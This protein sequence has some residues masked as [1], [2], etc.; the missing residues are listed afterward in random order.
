[1]SRIN[2]KAEFRTR[3]ISGVLTHTPSL[4]DSGAIFEF[5]GRVQ[6]PQAVCAQQ[7]SKAPPGATWGGGGE[8]DGAANAGPGGSGLGRG[9]AGSQM[10]EWQPAVSQSR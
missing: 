8:T 2:P 1:M 3:G 5:G 7:P 4:S 6:P 9:R 10:A